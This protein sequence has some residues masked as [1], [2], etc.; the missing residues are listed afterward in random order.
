MLSE[1]RVGPDATRSL[2]NAGWTTELVRLDMAGNAIGDGGAQALAGSQC[3]P[4]LRELDLSMNDI[5][6]VG[7][8]SDRGG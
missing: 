4:A 2:A 3:L 6:D 7:S 5:S 8:R 1:W